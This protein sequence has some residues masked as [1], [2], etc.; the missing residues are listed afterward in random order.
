MVEDR[1]SRQEGIRNWECGEHSVDDIIFFI[2]FSSFWFI[3]QY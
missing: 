1:L 2:V 3:T